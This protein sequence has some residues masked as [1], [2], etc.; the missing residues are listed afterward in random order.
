MTIESSMVDGMSISCSG[1]A[2]FSRFIVAFIKGMDSI[3]RKITSSIE[4]TFFPV[5]LFCPVIMFTIESKKAWNHSLNLSV[6]RIITTAIVAAKAQ[7]KY[8]F[9]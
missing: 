7:I 1:S 3:T 9:E 6:A 5:S 4:I 8:N 2:L